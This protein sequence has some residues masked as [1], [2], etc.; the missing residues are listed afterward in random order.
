M[1]YVVDASI[2]VEFL[3]QSA[4]GRHA[5]ALMSTGVLVAP[6]LLDAEVVAVLRRE[7]LGGRLDATR[8]TEA[9]ADLRDWD[10]ER[11]RHRELVTDVWALRHNVS[12]YDA[13][14]LATARLR[15]ATVLTADGPLSR[16]P[17]TGFMIQN[18]NV[19]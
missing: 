3:L 14:Y 18:L 16:I 10:I 8:A 19:I 11:I 9:I 17:I 1:T 15:D 4:V 13:F 5:G 2:A 6:E 7:V 12:A